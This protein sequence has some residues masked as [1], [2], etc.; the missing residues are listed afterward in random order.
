M[1][2]PLVSPGWLA[3]HL[4]DQDL[5]VADVRWYLADPEE[6]R[7]RYRREHIPGAVFLDLEEDLCSRQGAGRHPLPDPD[8]LARRLGEM[9]IG[10]QHLVA[11]YDDLGG[12][13]AA[14]LWWLL[15]HL[16]H[17]RAAV[18]DG[19]LPAWKAEGHPVT[20]RVPHL[21][22][23][24]FTARP[25]EGD[26]VDRE[27]LRR[28]LGQVVLLDARDPERYRGETEP[29][30]P[31]AGHIPGARNAPYRENL[32]PDGR[33]RPP[34]ELADRYRALG[35]T[36]ERPVVVSCGSGV[37][38]CHDLL[39]LEVAGLGE[40]ILYPGSWSDWCRAGLPV[41]VGADPEGS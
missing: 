1:T 38:A 10:D 22:P 13:V 20:D 8:R 28:R 9:G 16:G 26:T 17:P 33:F 18:L 27:E 25:R 5:R 34:A 30:D 6:G 19:G 21:P 41:A 14:R 40:G 11:A 2:R 32:R 4:E 12:A 15:R 31:V 36:G 3:D 37:T 7:R 24:R 23:A 29:V 35:V 39:A